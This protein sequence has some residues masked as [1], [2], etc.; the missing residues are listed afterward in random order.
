MYEL[1]VCS[2]NCECSFRIFPQ[3]NSTNR[4]IYIKSKTH[5][6]D[7]AQDIAEWDAIIQ[8]TSTM[9]K[10]HYVC[11]SATLKSSEFG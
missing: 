5:A 11:Y 3:L 9:L 2:V 10:K 7:Y 6:L 1:S 4:K 8:R